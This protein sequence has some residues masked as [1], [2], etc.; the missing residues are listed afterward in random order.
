MAITFAA[1]ILAGTVLLTLPVAQA[2]GRFAH[3]LTALFLATSATCVTGLSP[4]D[5]AVHLTLFGQ[6]VMLA[7]M[8]LGGLGI[9]TLGTFLFEIMGRRLSMSD[10]QV[11]MR[12]LAFSSSGKVRSLLWRTVV[13]SGVWEAIGAVLLGLRFFHVHGYSAPKAAYHG[14][15]HAV[16]AFCNAGFSLYPDSLSRF[17]DDPALLLIFSVLIVAGGL[18]FVV[19]NN[20]GSLAPWRRD[21]L[22]R[23]HLLLH[24]RIVLFGS[25]VLLA[26]GTLFVAAMEWNTG[27]AHLL[28]R[29]RW[30]GALFQSVTCRTAG[31]SAVDTASLGGGS[32][33]LSVVL[34]FVGGAPGSTAGGIK[35]ST[36]VVLLAT[37]VAMIRNRD[38][39]EFGRRTVPTATVRESIVITVLA[40][41]LVGLFATALHVTEASNRALVPASGLSF[42]LLFEAVSAFG[43]V[44]LSLG[45]TP[46]ISGLGQVLLIGC[47][48][49]GRLGPL[50]L[51]L[52]MS[53]AGQGPSRRY[54]EEN[55]VVG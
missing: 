13:F 9:M 23:G 31:F 55:V 51:A 39:T 12:S 3:P 45:V 22:R 16:S 24:T 36:A 19:Q 20:L 15:F 40:L 48:F 49:V 5:I 44:G 47:M 42:A 30:I 28:P 21:R 37:V 54:P 29:D 53:G 34:M 4:V 38:E 6:L 43:T 35:L 52:T 18:G 11:L 7:L 26:L 46:L 32:K 17:A 50:T 1:A 14:V 33:A 2:S 27:L 41:L 25:A 8:Q 10:E